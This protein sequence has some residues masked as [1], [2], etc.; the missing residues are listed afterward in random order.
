MSQALV[1]R[2]SA[3]SV[4]GCMYVCVWILAAEKL[5]THTTVRNLTWPSSVPSNIRNADM[6][7]A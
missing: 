6:S 1:S 2:P 7:Y 4:Q 5:S 3:E